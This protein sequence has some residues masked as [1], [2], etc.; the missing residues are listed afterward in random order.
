V[1]FIFTRETFFC[2]IYLLTFKRL[3]EIGGG[4]NSENEIVRE[5]RVK[6]L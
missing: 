4:L 3:Y 5:R 1:I 2:K 6:F